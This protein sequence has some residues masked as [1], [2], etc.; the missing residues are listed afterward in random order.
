MDEITTLAKPVKP[1]N[2]SASC[3]QYIFYMYIRANVWEI[4]KTDNQE[5]Q[6]HFNLSIQIQGDEF[7]YL[8]N[9]QNDHHNR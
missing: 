2:D 8:L 1:A 6:N 9:P 5:E 4:S 7:D 3:W